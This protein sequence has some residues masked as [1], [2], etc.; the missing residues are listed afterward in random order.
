MRAMPLASPY[1]YDRTGALLRNRYNWLGLARACWVVTNPLA[2]FAGLLRHRAPER[3]SVRTPTGTITLALRNFESLKTLFGIFCRNDYATESGR[4]FF[5][6]DIGANVG[7][8]SAYF[9]SRNRANR[10]CCYEPDETNL[11]WLTRNLAAFPGRATIVNRAVAPASGETVLYRADTGKHSALH[12][13]ELA[14]IPQRIAASGF[15]EVLAGAAAGALPTV[16]KLDVEG[17]EEELIKSVRFENYPQLRRLLCESTVC[18]QLITRPHR[19][20]LRNGYIEDLRF[21]G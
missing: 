5:F 18:S 19:R 8:A 14:T 12:P 4:A 10:V 6:F 3:L 16:V 2:F 11:A 7:F 21:V 20:A 9:L 13:N 15:G 1:A 17:V